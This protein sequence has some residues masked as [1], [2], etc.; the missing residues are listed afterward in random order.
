MDSAKLVLASGSPRRLQLLASLGLEC[1]VFP[2]DLDES[3]RPGEAPSV[4]ACRLAAEKA[5]AAVARLGSERLVLAADTVV[6]LG[7]EIFGKPAGAAEAVRMLRRLSGRAH[8]VHTAV[9]AAQG[10]RTSLRLSSS[11]VRFND[12][13]DEEIEAYV[14]SGEPLDKAGAYGIQGLA[15]VFVTRLCGSYSGVVGLPLFETA[16]LLREHGIDVIRKPRGPRA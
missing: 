4:Y 7:D 15:A 1:E 14:A 10:D 11:E 2:V 8:E 13:A 12:L 5:G 6:A 9:A 3:P 16:E